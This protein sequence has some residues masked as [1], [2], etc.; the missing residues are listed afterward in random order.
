MHNRTELAAD[1]YNQYSAQGYN[2]DAA[3]AGNPDVTVIRFM[4]ATSYVTPA[5]AGYV[6]IAN[7]VAA[8]TVVRVNRRGKYAAWMSL[9]WNAHADTTITQ[10]ISKNAVAGMLVADPV[11]NA[12]FANGI[13]QGSLMRTVLPAV[14]AVEKSTISSCEFD[15]TDAEAAA[16]SGALIRFHAGDA[17]ATPSGNAYSEPTHA[18]FGVRY[19]GESH[20]F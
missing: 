20:A 1:R 19:L 7:T 5:A 9:S 3:L 11:Y 15:V 16:G 8:G 18:S 2:L 12:A 13:L 6:S 4:A 17:D 14:A 10:A